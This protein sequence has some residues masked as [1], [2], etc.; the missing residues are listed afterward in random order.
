MR[1]YSTRITEGVD[2]AASPGRGSLLQRLHYNYGTWSGGC[3]VVKTIV[4]TS[5]HRQWFT[6]HST[7]NLPRPWCLWDE[8][9]RCP[10]NPGMAFDR[11]PPTA[12][13]A[14]VLHL[15]CRT[16][17]DWLVRKSLTGRIDITPSG[18]PCPTCFGSLEAIIEE[19]SACCPARRGIH[20]YEKCTDRPKGTGAAQERH[21]DPTRVTQY[22]QAVDASVQRARAALMRGSNTSTAWLQTVDASVQRARAA[23]Y[24]DS[25][26]TDGTTR[27]LRYHGGHE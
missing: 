20:N 19:Y 24:V 23:Q 25:M 5:T 22:L 8:Q 27:L 16:L 14:F 7:R 9:L 1:L 11:R 21:L 18:N 12:H 17:L 26:A 13:M 2:T 10:A 6:P 4:R 3:C 15:Q